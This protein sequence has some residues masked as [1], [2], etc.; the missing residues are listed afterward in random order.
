MV[1][2]QHKLIGVIALLTFGMQLSINVMASPQQDCVDKIN[3]LRATIGLVPLQRWKDQESC[4]DR[5]IQV[6]AD[7]G[8]YHKSIRSGDNCGAGA[9]NVC[10]GSAYSSIND[11]INK[12]PLDQWRES[13]D[14]GPQ[15]HYENLATSTATHVACGFYEKS[16]GSIWSNMNFGTPQ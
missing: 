14:D 11:L 15:G 16:D 4:V 10:A 8:Q 5:T 13:E 12:C 1:K 9:Q 2:K 7:A 6:D 3:E